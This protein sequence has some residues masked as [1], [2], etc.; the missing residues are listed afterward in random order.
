L[1]KE[2]QKDKDDKYWEAV[3]RQSV[4][5]GMIIKEIENYGV[6]KVTPMGKEFVQSPK[7]FQLV[8][9]H[10]YS[11]VDD[12]DVIAPQRSSGAADET[13]F[14]ILKDLRKSI[15]KQKG[16]PPFV[17]FQDP[18]LEDMATRYPITI[19]ELTAIS[20]VGQGKA[21]KFG[22]EF[23]EVIANYV[24]E[25]DIER[26]M[27]MVVKSVVNKSGLKV[28]VVQSIDRKIDLEDIADAKGLS[29][30]ELLNELEIIVHSGTKLNLDYYIN[31]QID[32]ADQ[33][34]VF[35]YFMEAKSDSLDDAMAEF[36]D[37]FSEEEMRLLRIK[38]FSNVAN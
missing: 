11:D 31:E 10:D 29:M 5:G 22:Q 25:N 34:E 26:P 23:I 24:E 38:F 12:G 6:L 28:Y 20:G 1:A 8:K 19:E 33:E 18:S 21:E 27:D 37:A 15:A 32:E 4:V 36:D 14:A 9:P 13:L 2:K 16:F 30:D 3:I 17:L 7:S 35:D